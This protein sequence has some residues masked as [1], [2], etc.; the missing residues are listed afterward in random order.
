M[1]LKVL[2]GAQ[3]GCLT[4]VIFSETMRQSVL[5]TLETG[6]LLVSRLQKVRLQMIFW[7]I[8]GRL[9]PCYIQRQMSVKPQHV[10]VLFQSI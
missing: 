10:K 6:N 5:L 1:C 9:K 7:P 3:L 2:T 8:R 4:L